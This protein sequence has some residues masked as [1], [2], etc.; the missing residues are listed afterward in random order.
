MNSDIARE[1]AVALATHEQVEITGGWK[2]HP[3]VVLFPEA[4]CP[5]CKSVIKSLA[6]WL[7]RENFLIGQAVPVSGK[8]FVLDRPHHPHATPSAICMGNATDPLQALF[9]GLNPESVWCDPITWLQ[10]KYWEHSCDEMAQALHSEDDYCCAGCE[11]YFDEEDVTLYL[12][13]YYC[14]PC[15]SERA[16]R[17]FNCDC[18]YSNDERN[19]AEDE[20]YCDDCYS[21]RFFTCSVCEDIKRLNQNVSED[22]CEDCA[23]KCEDCDEWFNSEKKFNCIYCIRVV[24]PDCESDHEECEANA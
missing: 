14:D 8:P 6:I 9:Y 18:T 16:F 15:F 19:S 4:Q 21:E 1:V 17:C 13:S 22:L 20:S 7:V 23:T 24:C 5:Y 10:G 3:G 2:W 12:D 11:D